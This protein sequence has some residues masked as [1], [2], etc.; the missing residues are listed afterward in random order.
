LVIFT[1][2]TA[3]TR[4]GVGLTPAVAAAVPKLV[5]AVMAELTQAADYRM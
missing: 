1:V 5:E 2:D 4:D 3:D